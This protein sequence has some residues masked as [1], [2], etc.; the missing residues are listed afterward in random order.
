MTL[1]LITFHRIHLKA[2]SNTAPATRAEV[3]MQAYLN[4]YLNYQ[5]E[6]NL[7]QDIRRVQDRP[8]ARLQHLVP[9]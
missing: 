7:K 3:R 1:F 2:V 9:T 6:S 4:S 5:N 8:H